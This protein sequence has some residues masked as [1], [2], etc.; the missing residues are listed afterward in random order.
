MSQE[1]HNLDQAL[2]L[3]GE[4]LSVRKTADYDL[5]VCGGSALLAAGIISRSTNDVDVLAKKDGEGTIF[6]AHPLPKALEEAAAAVAKE[7][8]LKSNWL[9]SSASFHF[10]DY[11]LLPSSFWTDVETRDY[12]DYLRLRFVN[13]SGQI[14]LK[15]YA[16][17]NRNETRDLEDLRALNPKATETEAAVRW[18]LDSIPGLTQI[19]KLPDI[20]HVLG[21]D[22]IRERLPQ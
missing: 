10:P 15:F 18:L 7:L 21:H 2:T 12:G 13:R 6:R 19:H 16:V 1:S 3:L 22:E 9:N 8:G 5:V 14:L 11:H 4:L 20:L 17:L